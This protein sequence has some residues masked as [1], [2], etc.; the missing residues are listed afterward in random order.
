MDNKQKMST[1]KD[2]LKSGIVTL[3]V[4]LISFFASG[5]YSRFQKIED[6]ASKKDLESVEVKC[7]S[8]TDKQIQNSESKTNIEINSMKETQDKTYQMVLFLYNKEIT[9]Q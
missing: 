3:S 7:N 6:S 1:W 8:Y 9:K 4:L 2:Y 5:F